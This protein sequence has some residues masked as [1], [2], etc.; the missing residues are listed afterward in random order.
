MSRRLTVRSYYSRLYPPNSWSEIFISL[1][2][3]HIA[4]DSFDCP[5]Y[6]ID[7]NPKKTWA[8]FFKVTSIRPKQ[9][10][11]LNPHT[12]SLDNLKRIL[13]NVGISFINPEKKKVRSLEIYEVMKSSNDHPGNTCLSFL[14]GLGTTT[15]YILIQSQWIWI[16]AGY[17]K[18]HG[19]W[20]DGLYYW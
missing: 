11:D 9:F 19:L 15:P 1:G 4:W 14:L 13:K 20:L 8:W 6:P 16:K 10:E 5:C 17:P 18:N 2:D 7:K 12:G 3:P